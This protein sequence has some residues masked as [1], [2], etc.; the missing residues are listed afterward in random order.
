MTKQVQ[1]QV[2]D[3]ALA[4]GF[5]I[6]MLPT[7]ERGGDRGQRYKAKSDGDE[8]AS[9]G[10]ANGYQQLVEAKPDQERRGDRRDRLSNA[11]ANQAG[12][13]QPAMPGQQRRKAQRRTLTKTVA[14]QQRFR[15]AE[16]TLRT[17]SSRHQ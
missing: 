3:I 14:F 11:V 5:C 16:A 10:R 15:P 1:P 13:Q 7:P 6:D 9:G 4:E 17:A 12:E 8:S 2:M